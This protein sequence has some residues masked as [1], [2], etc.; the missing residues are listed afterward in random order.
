MH[1][2]HTR[3]GHVSLSKMQHIP[4]YDCKHMHEYNCS[5][6]LHSKQHKLPFPVSMS[7]ANQCFDLIHIDLWGPYRVH[8]LNGAKYF[9]T[10][11]DDHSRA[12]WT[13]LLNKKLQVATNISNFLTMVETQFTKFVKTVRSDNGT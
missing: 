6:C 10:I 11:V 4:G 12:T 5:V 2:L 1:L 9:L 7:K 8:A 3:L 13:F